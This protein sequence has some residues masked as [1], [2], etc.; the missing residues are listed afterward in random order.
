M[1]SVGRRQ[2]CTALSSA[3]EEASGL[4]GALGQRQ[5]SCTQ[6][7]WVTAKAADS[8]KGGTGK[9]SRRQDPST[10]EQ[11]WGSLQPY[12]SRRVPIGHEMLCKTPWHVGPSHRAS[13]CG[14]LGRAREDHGQDAASDSETPPRQR[15]WSCDPIEHQVLEA[16][17]A[18][19]D[20]LPPCFRLFP[21]QAEYTPCKPAWTQCFLLFRTEKNEIG[22]VA[23][24]WVLASTRLKN[25][26]RL[27]A[28][29][30]CM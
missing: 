17:V 27:K 7:L 19:Q 23:L 20:A 9:R 4:G 15:A 10:P 21:P 25:A 12:V 16:H 3:G 29:Y 5:R 14:H 6:S 26:R 13:G 24:T 28:F 11:S 30:E 22:E 1:P 2:P 18:I 8:R